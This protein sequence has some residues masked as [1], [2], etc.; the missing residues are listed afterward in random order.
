MNMNMDNQTGVLY[1]LHMLNKLSKSA[2]GK[3]LDYLDNC[4]WK[5]VAIPLVFA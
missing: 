1:W 2:C 3:V 5:R 4:T